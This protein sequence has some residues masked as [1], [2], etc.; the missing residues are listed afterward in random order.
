M[1]ARLAKWSMN[2]SHMFSAYGSGEAVL[3][4]ILVGRELGM[5]AMASL[6]SIHNIKNKHSLSADLMVGLV[7]KSGMADYFRMVEST[8]CGSHLRDESE[9]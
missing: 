4:T 8:D 9:G 1:P 3:S 5:P 7:L 2:K 6:R